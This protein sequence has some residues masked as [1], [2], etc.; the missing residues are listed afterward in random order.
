MRDERIGRLRRTLDALHVEFP[1]ED[2]LPE[3]PVSILHGYGEPADREVAGLIAACLSLG[4]A[5]SIRAKTRAVLE[6]MG[7]HPARFVV[8]FRPHRDGGRFSGW[9]HRWYRAQDLI[10]LLWLLRQT[11]LRHG[12]LERC[13][14]LGC[15]EG[16]QDPGA[17]ISRFVNEITSGDP[18]PIFPTS[19]LP[20]RWMSLLP[21]PEGGSACK[22]INLYLRWM[23]RPDDGVDTGVWRRVSPARLVIPLDTHVTRIARHLGL[24]KRK[25]PGWQMALEVTRTLRLLDPD[26]PVKYDFLLCHLGMAGRCPW[27]RDLSRCPGCRHWGRCLIG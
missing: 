2:R 17:A 20:R 7:P 12:S 19:R 23:V 1:Y 6:R 5:A 9:A 21:S 16:D 24:T 18:R 14:L 8:K 11:L 4:R 26:D 22:R 13:F 27:D 3:D 10:C 25:T 15:Q